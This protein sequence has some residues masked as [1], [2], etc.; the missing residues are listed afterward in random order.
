MADSAHAGGKAKLRWLIVGAGAI[1]GFLGVPLSNRGH[2]VTFLAR[3]AH[4]AAM[5]VAGCM[6]LIHA[7]GREETSSCETSTFTDDLESLPDESYDVV[8][9]ALKM[10]Q[11]ESI[12]TQLPRLLDK[13]RGVYLTTQNGVPWWYFQN[14]AN[15]NDNTNSSI[16]QLK[17][18]RIDAVDPNGILKDTIDCDRLLACVVYPAA[19]ILKPGVIEHMNGTRFPVGELN[20][21]QTPRVSRISSALIS[22]GFKSPI[23]PD[24]RAELWLK[25]WGTVAVNPLSALTH[26]TLEELCSADLPGRAV[27][28]SVMREVESIMTAL[29]ESMRVPLE[30]RVNGA[31]RVGAHK[32]SMLSDVEKGKHIEVDGVMGAVVELA[33]KTQVETPALDTLYGT[34]R[35]L[36]WV[37]K[38]KKGKLC[39]ESIDTEVR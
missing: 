37:L 21:E 23:L 8:V 35:M 26:S 3:G 25:L 24:I 2:S 7:D 5:K 1:G 12:A 6:K 39:V 34:V 11:I 28:E 30:R 13:E 20:G 29:G 9:L 36:E 10:H 27:V 15:I 38:E 17:D 18:S 31:A 16:S 14:N 4:L 32:T 22:A 33:R 19:K